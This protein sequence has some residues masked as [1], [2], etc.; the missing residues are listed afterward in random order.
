MKILSSNTYSIFCCI[1]I[2]HVKIKTTL[3]LL[4]IIDYLL[5]KHTLY[6]INLMKN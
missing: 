2:L 6:D 5:F 3:K 4:Y 1:A